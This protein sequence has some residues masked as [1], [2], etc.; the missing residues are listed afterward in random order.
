[1]AYDSGR[2]VTV[3]FGGSAGSGET[4]EWN[5]TAWTQRLVSGPAPEYFHAM[6]YDSARGVTVLYGGILSGGSQTWEWN[7][8]AW[9]QRSV[10]GPGNRSGHT[11]AY[12][13][14]R[15]VTVLFGGDSAGGVNSQTWEWDG[16]AW[17][18][19]VVGAHPSSR[20]LQAMA[21][22]ADRGVTVLFGGA[23]GGGSAG[24][25]SDTWEW[26]GAGAGA[27]T[28]RLVGGPSAR[29]SH[30]MAYDSGRGVTVLFGGLTADLNANGE[31]W[32]LGVSCYANCDGSTTVPVLN[33][34]DFVCFQA[35]FAAGDPRANC[36][37]ST[38]PPVLNVSDFVCFQGAFA[39]GCG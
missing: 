37:G 8:T 19:R 27:W 36:D 24:F 30:A 33:V 26:N 10:A 4:W 17:T 14:A 31:T 20:Y 13:A 21:C 2:G 12:D 29:E 6:A 23:T 18:Q 16:T 9:T 25:M 3:L 7:G 28:Q 35:E 5:G 22:D 1:M 39:A 34:N 11:M 15:H 38:A 32:E